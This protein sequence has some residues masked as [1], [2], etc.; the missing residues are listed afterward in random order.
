MK[1]FRKALD[2]AENM[3]DIEIHCGVCS[4]KHTQK[5][6]MPDG[7]DSRYRSL[8]DE[9]AFCPKHAVIAEFADS[10]C[11]GCVGGWG[12][13][14]LWRAFAYSKL[15]LT[16]GDFRTIEMGICPKRT[17]GTF[18]V[19]MPEGK[20]EDI[21]LRDPPNVEGGKALAK[22]IRQYALKYHKKDDSWAKP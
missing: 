6:P 22:A 8:S 21:D 3:L 5:I 19:S 13:C 17:G 1:D 7:W 14:D 16:P 20:F 2:G 10:Q 4:A 15:E 18:S 11:P 9:T 12:D